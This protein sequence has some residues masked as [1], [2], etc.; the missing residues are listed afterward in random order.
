M[1]SGGARHR[2]KM[3]TPPPIPILIV[4]LILIPTPSLRAQSWTLTDSS[5]TPTQ[6]QLT[7]LTPTSITTSTTTLPWQTQLSLT[8]EAQPTDPDPYQIV[9][10]TN[11][12]LSGSAAGV[13]GEKLQW[14][15]PLLGEFF[16]PVDQV[17][18]IYRSQYPPKNLTQPR[19]DD[20]IQLNNGDSAHGIVSN[21]CAL[22]VTFQPDNSTIATTLPWT[23][24]TAVLFSTSPQP[25]S[26]QHLFRLTLSDGSQVSVPAIALSQS[27]LTVTL[28]DQTTHPLDPA[29]VASIEQLNGPLTWL[30]DRTP[31]TITYK[32][33]F[34]EFFPPHFDATYDNKP[35]P[36][37]FEGFH[38][39]ISCHSNTKLD[40][41][42]DPE[43]TTFRTQFAIDSDSS[44]ADVTVRIFLDDKLAYEQK[45]IKAGQIYPV[46][47]IP[48][49]GAKTLSLE[50]DY[51]QTFSTQGRFVWLDPALL[52]TPP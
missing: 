2:A 49:T 30:T 37:K 31:T 46:T 51:G 24:V 47:T 35:I 41:A 5:L 26:T 50:V 29:Q 39:G 12:H 33:Y 48:L 10:T 9:L 22:G 34:T 4:I 19:T 52:K 13:F 28:P 38:H 21:V 16:L 8:H 17:A 25:P 3:K 11:D 14:K 40:Y 44:L 20:I 7:T 23:T 45:N 18:A 1:F 27:K 42:L 6:I 32:P 36:Q 15:N 43:F